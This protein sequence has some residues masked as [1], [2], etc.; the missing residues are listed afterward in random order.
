MSKRT[1]V[2]GNEDV[3]VSVGMPVIVGYPVGAIAGVGLPV[4][5]SL[6]A[7][8]P[9]ADPVDEV[10][11]ATLSSEGLPVGLLAIIVVGCLV[12]GAFA[13]PA[14]TAAAAGWGAAVAAIPSVMRD[15][16]PMMVSTA[17]SY[18]LSF[19]SASPGV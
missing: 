9:D 15:T 8:D 19:F 7:N 11:L 13:A 6:G 18:S 17:S 12:G 2:G 1:I 10:T 4:S 16:I 14:A 5:P 3:G